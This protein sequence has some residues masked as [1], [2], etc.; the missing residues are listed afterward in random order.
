MAGPYEE[1]LRLGRDQLGPLV[2]RALHAHRGVVVRQR[3]EDLPAHT[4]G[5]HAPGE[6]LLR[7]GQR[8]SETSYIVCVGP[9][10][11]VNPWH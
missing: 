4:E 11:D 1:L 5:R 6:P 7:L 2:D 9:V 10:F 8:E 3:R